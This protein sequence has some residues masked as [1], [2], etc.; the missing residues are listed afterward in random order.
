MIGDNS[1]VENRRY[2]EQYV[3]YSRIRGTVIDCNPK[4]MQG[5]VYWIRGFINSMLVKVETVTDAKL[6]VRVGHSPDTHWIST[7][8]FLAGVATGRITGYMH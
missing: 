3:G 5:R 1:I 7:I 2:V 8:Q 4:V 6:E